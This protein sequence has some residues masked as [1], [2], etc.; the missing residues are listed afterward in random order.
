MKFLLRFWLDLGQ[1]L[2]DFW[3]YSRSLW[4]TFGVLRWLLDCFWE[5]SGIV[6]H[7][8]WIFGR[9]LVALGAILVDLAPFCLNLGSRIGTNCPP[10]SNL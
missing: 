2:D 7:Q 3:S 4:I 8:I 5:T 6:W 9:S 10:K 1:F